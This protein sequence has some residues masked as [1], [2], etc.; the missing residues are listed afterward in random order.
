MLAPVLLVFGEERCFF[1]F[2]EFSGGEMGEAGDCFGGEFVVDVAL[3]MG[4]AGGRG[5]GLMVLGVGTG[6]LRGYGCCGA[7]FVEFREVGGG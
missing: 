3:G 6:E 4:L 2:G 1:L 7:K 5:S